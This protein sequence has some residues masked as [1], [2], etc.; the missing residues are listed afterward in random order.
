MKV[1]LAR[2]STGFVTGGETGRTT[3]PPQLLVFL[4]GFSL[5]YLA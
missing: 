5:T 2:L 1:V 4:N 3:A